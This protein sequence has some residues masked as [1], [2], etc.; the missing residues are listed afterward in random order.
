MIHGTHA[1]VWASMVAVVIAASDGGC[2]DVRGNFSGVQRA[3]SAGAQG[4]LVPALQPTA[5]RAVPVPAPVRTA[6]APRRRLAESVPTGYLEGVGADARLVIP[7]QA[8]HVN[9]GT[10][11]LGD[12]YGVVWTDP[13]VST[14]YF[15]RLAADGHPTGTASVVHR[16][17]EDEEQIASPVV[18]ASSDG[19][20]IAWVDPE[21]GRVCFARLDASGALRGRTSIVH[22]G[23]EAPRVAQIVWNG[24][25]FGLAVGQWRGVYFARVAD[26]GERVGDGVL[27]DEGTSV[28][29]LDGIRW[30]GRGYT[31]SWSQRHD[32]FATHLRQRLGSDGRRQGAAA[33][34]GAI[35]RPRSM[36]G[37][38]RVM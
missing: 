23:L 12:G 26:T 18:T 29:S 8:D 3:V 6:E 5:P 28:G 22:D 38:S 9:V 14:V 4:A 27:I 15:G 32:G 10:A 11:R 36:R 31:V 25:E 37:G 24:H 13:A 34:M 16:V 7:E 19:Y 2:Q 35:D 30:D 17:V 33:V 20:G 21:N 1:K